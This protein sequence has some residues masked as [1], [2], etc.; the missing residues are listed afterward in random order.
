MDHR[1]KVSVVEVE[2]VGAHRIDE[3]GIQDVEP[4]G[5]PEHRG[6]RRTGKAGEKL[7][8][9]I[10]VGMACRAK[11][12]AQHVQDRALPFMPNGSGDIAPT[13]A[14]Y[15]LSPTRRDIVCCGTRLLHRSL[16]RLQISVRDAADA[17]LR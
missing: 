8:R 5:A 6:L 7:D 16:R 11:R 10:E 2:Q 12:A 9:G 3:R 4:L 17:D 15:K 1:I 13:R 14:R